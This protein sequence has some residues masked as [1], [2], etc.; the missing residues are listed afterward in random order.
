MAEVGG[1]VAPFEHPRQLMGL[2][3]SGSSP[4]ATRA[5]ERIRR[6]AISKAGNA[7][8]R[9][10]VVEA[11]WAYSAKTGPA[12]GN[13]LAALQRHSSAE[14]TA[15]AWKAQTAPASAATYGLMGAR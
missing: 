6:G 4:R 7:H 15:L 9:R 8:L 12:I 13:T 5:G 3:G 14:V 2:L 1:A 10:I 11:A